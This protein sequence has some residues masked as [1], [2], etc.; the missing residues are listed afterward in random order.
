MGETFVLMKISGKFSFLLS[1][2][3]TYMATETAPAF[4]V[5]ALLSLY[6][7]I[8]VGTRWIYKAGELCGIKPVRRVLPE[9]CYTCLIREGF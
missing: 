9:I 3:S 6:P 4:R 2:F 1:D 5:K 7:R 8:Y